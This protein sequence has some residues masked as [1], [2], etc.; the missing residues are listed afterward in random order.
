ML[1]A[2]QT[3][4][5]QAL[6]PLFGTE[7]LPPV[8]E[9]GGGG[10]ATQGRKEGQIVGPFLATHCTTLL[11]LERCQPRCCM[12]HE[13]AERCRGTKDNM[14]ESVY[15]RLDPDCLLYDGVKP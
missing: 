9:T 15:E 12:M 10:N 6:Q 3:Y 8:L 14:G 13:N 4:N 7:P 11:H 2:H 5:S 1:E